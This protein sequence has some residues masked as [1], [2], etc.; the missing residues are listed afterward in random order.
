MIAYSWTCSF[1]S[2]LLR[3]DL[4]PKNICLLPKDLCLSLEFGQAAAR[5]R[6]L[7]LLLENFNLPCKFLRRSFPIGRSGELFVGD[8]LLRMQFGDLCFEYPYLKPVIPAK[9]DQ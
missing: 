8:G 9:P 5:F 4:A 3:I 6:G 7:R 2:L 1:L